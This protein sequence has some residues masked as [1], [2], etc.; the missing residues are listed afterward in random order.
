MKVLHIILNI[1]IHIFVL[2]L[3]PVSIYLTDVN[4]WLALG[5]TVLWIVAVR[6][7]EILIKKHQARHFLSKAAFAILDVIIIFVMVLE[8]QFNAYW[9]TYT[10]RVKELNSNSGFSEI[11]G[12]QAVSDFDYA[13]N[14]LRKIHPMAYDGL[15]KEVEDRA[16]EVREELKNVDSIEGY[17]LSQKL[18]SI[19]AMLGDGHTH[20]DAMFSDKHYMKHLYEHIKN[21]DTLVGI[22]GIT[23]VEY[24]KQH[25]E[26]VS[27]EME[28]Y[29]VLLV[30]GLSKHLEGLTYLG[31]D[32]SGEITY[33]YISEDGKPL[34]ETVS[35]EDFLLNEDYLCYEEEIT[36]DD[37]HATSE[38]KDF[39]R[40]EIDEN[41]SLATLTIDSSDYNSH[42]REVVKAMFDE[43]DKKNIQNVAVD[44]RNNGGGSSLIADEFIHYLEVEEYKSWPSEIRYGC[45]MP[46]FDGSVTKN[47]KKGSGFTGNVYV[48]TSYASYSAAMDFAMLIQDNGLG[49]IIGEPCGNLPSS[50]G[51]VACFELP[52][53]G[54]YMQISRKCWHRVDESKEDLPIIPDYSCRSDECEQ[55]LENLLNNDI[56][57]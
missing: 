27:F 8:T 29:G 3:I 32:T 34:E 49:K 50:Y 10:N 12:R 55:E 47:H 48:Y 40:Y 39:V 26:T 16:S 30:K 51:D 11:T 4:E 23:Y 33:N 46:H 28:E 17:Q 38:E 56:K 42:Y 31:V 54:L 37:L 14:Y 19:F 24:L 53:S 6:V 5:L 13:M 21:G 43:V 57:E 18:E 52:E 2:A 9:N 22:N 1:L 41:K 7:G 20:V 15:P 44:L 45:F 35:S 25:P 36:G